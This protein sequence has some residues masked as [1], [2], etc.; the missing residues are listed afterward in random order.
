MAARAATIGVAAKVAGVVF[1]CEEGVFEPGLSDLFEPLA[2]ISSSAHTIKIL[3]NDRV[4]GIWQLKPIEWLVAVVTRSR[5]HR[6]THLGSSASELL[7]IWQIPD[8]HIRAVRRRWRFC[9]GSTTQRWHGYF[10]EFA[11]NKLLDFYWLHRRADGNLAHH[12]AGFRRPSK[13]VCKISRNR[14]PS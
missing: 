9:V 10:F 4:I 3:W 5:C 2:V 1:Q 13:C 8:N 7:Q 6:E 14:E 11:V 12:R